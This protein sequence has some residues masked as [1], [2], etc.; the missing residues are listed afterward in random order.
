MELTQKKQKVVNVVKHQDILELR[1]QLEKERNEIAEKIIDNQIGTGGQ[2]VRQ[3][4]RRD[5]L[6]EMI[7]KLDEL[8]GVARQ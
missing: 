1:N 3:R 5:F 6:G 7:H 2:A 4:C 8:A